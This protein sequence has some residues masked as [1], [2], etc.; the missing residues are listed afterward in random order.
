MLGIPFYSFFSICLD[1]F[2]F[3]FCDNFLLESI[4][5]LPQTSRNIWWNCLFPKLDHRLDLAYAMARLD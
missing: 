2:S 4:F 5:V 3:I 1:W